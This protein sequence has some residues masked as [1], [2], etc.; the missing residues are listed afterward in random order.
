[1]AVSKKLSNYLAKRQASYR[2]I[3]HKKT[4]SASRTVE[5]AEISPEQLAKA[6]L[7]KSKS[8]YVVAL[9][10]ASNHIKMRRL[11][12]CLKSRVRIAKEREIQ[13]LFHDCDP[14][15]IPAIGIAYGVKTLVDDQLENE[16]DIY[17]EA[18]DHECLVHMT[19]EEF[20]KLTADMLHANVGV[21][22]WREF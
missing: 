14:G 11:R 8:D 21:H 3:R 10:P 4:L 5:A 17:F 6:V 7:I 2:V 9:I 13:P 19:G 16:S 18:G 12:R 15:A 22:N 20:K 1:M